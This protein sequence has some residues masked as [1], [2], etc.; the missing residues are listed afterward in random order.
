MVMSI[1]SFGGINSVQARFNWLSDILQSISSDFVEN[2]YNLLNCQ[3]SYH[4]CSLQ[5][6]K[7]KYLFF[8]VRLLGCTWHALN[9]ERERERERERTAKKMYIYFILSYYITCRVHPVSHFQ[10]KV[11]IFKEGSLS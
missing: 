11:H 9:S 7:N 4:E 1:I 10:W 5:T 6:W 2:I 3:H 8:G